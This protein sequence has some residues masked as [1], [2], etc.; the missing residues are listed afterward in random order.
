MVRRS[1]LSSPPSKSDRF[2]HRLGLLSGIF[3]LAVVAAACGDSGTS[4]TPVSTSATPTTGQTSTVPSST[5][6]VAATVPTTVA[7][8]TTLAPTTTTIA[9][10]VVVIELGFSEGQ[11]QGEDRYEVDGG[12]VVRIML[13]SDVTD[14][15]HVHGYDV[16]GDVAPDVPAVIEFTAD[17]PGIF[18]V[19]LEEVGRVL[20]ELVVGA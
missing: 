4:P 11:V 13:T 7:A 10:G 9:D 20:F 14:E 8:T 17:I 16:F 3:T 12:A 6:T 5:T 2:V 18:E 19:E 15:V 1:I